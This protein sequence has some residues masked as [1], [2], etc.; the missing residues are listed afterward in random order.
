MEATEQVKISESK[1]NRG[2]PKKDNTLRGM[3]YYNANKEEITKKKRE[4]YIKNVE[5]LREYRKRSI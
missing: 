1:T 4:Y 3:D 5:K 2:R